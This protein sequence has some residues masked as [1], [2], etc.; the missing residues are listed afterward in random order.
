MGSSNGEEIWR[1]V[2]FFTSFCSHI[3]W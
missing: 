3:Y 1:D 2:D